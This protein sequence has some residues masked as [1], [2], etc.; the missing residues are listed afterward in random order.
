MSYALTTEL[1]MEALIAEPPTEFASAA[2]ADGEE[3]QRQIAT[4][5]RIPRLNE[6]YDAVAD[7]VVIL[8]RHRQIIYV[9]KA[10]EDAFHL[11]PDSHLR[12]AARRGLEL[13]ALRQDAR[14]VRNDAVLQSMRGREGDSLG[15]TGKEG[16]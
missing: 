14:R 3:L 5:S 9:N 13:P 16:I 10:L 15:A 11:G 6:L 7:I 4:V 8:N 2:R 12:T 1:A